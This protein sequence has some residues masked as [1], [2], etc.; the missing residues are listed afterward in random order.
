MSTATTQ[1]QYDELIADNYDLDPLSI[2]SD[3][4]DRALMQLE[5]HGCLEGVLPAMSVFDVGMG[6][7]L[8]LEKLAQSTA[9][10]LHPFG[11][12]ISARMLEVA[13]RRVSNLLSALDDAANL[14][15]HFDFEQFDLVCTHFITGFVPLRVLAPKI[16]QRLK[17][18][19]YWSFVGATSSAYP[20]LQK[21]ASSK[22]MQMLL[23]N[24][25]IEF[26]SLI[27]PTN[28]REVESIA[29]EH[30]YEVSAAE[31]WEPE[32]RFQNFDEFIDFSYH[33]GWL[34]PFI[35]ELGLQKARP[36]LRALLN[37][38]SFPLEDHHTIVVALL[39]RAPL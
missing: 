5:A 19:G 13:H 36:A 4:L 9:R 35:E 8:F 21:K 29:E 33:G 31:T 10:E 24:K 14:D 26:S 23:G 34:T 20:T 18:G 17:P 39:R 32:L 27:T 25:R 3:T 28:Q 22:L 11:L 37:T 16:L 30:A 12:D 15:Q 2:T 6:T 38:F 7:G 1:R